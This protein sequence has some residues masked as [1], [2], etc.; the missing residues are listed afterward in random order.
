[1]VE[2]KV[3]FRRKVSGTEPSSLVVN[4][5]KELLKALDIKKGDYLKCYIDEGKHG[6]FLAFWPEKQGEGEGEEGE[7]EKELNAE[8]I[9]E[10]IE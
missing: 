6:S 1:M 9:Q 2:S 3:M 7:T 8:E 5:P 4:L 10:N